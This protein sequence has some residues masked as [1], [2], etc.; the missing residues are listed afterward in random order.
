MFPGSIKDR[1]EPRVPSLSIRE[2]SPYPQHHTGRQNHSDSTAQKAP[3]PAYKAS[4]GQ[5][6]VT[7][8]KN[9]HHIYSVNHD[10]QS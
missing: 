2:L 6:P 10:T 8:E 4:I 7:A 9:V 1:S 5:E 3:T